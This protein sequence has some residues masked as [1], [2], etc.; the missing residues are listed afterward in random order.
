MQIFFFFLPRCYHNALKGAPQE[1]DW[2]DAS[3]CYITWPLQPNKGH[4]T[5]LKPREH[6]SMVQL[7][8]TGVFS[9]SNQNI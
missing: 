8:I 4:L 2:K 7:T 9:A 5:T 1:W 3:V 6:W